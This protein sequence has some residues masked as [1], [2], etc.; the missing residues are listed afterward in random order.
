MRRR[1]SQTRLNRAAPLREPVFDLAVLQR[2]PALHESPARTLTAAAWRR[3]RGKRLLGEQVRERGL[4]PHRRAD[5]HNQIGRVGV[6]R[7]G[8]LVR[9]EG[10]VVGPRCGIV[11]C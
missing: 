1:E 4:P 7:P 6:A 3:L 9:T 10:Q 8:R 11:A 2:W 5:L